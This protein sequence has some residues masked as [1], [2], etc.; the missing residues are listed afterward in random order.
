M[1]ISKTVKDRDEGIFRCEVTDHH[2][3]K[4]TDGQ[5]V[6]I[7]DKYFIKLYEDNEKSSIT[8]AARKKGARINIGYTAYPT[9]TTVIWTN[10]RGIEISNNG[11][12]LRKNKYKIEKSEK[13]II[14]T[15]TNP[16]LRDFGTYTLFASNDFTNK[17]IGIKLLVLGKTRQIL[18][19]SILSKFF[20]NI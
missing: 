5:H 14:L 11:N 17:S 8:I 12:V 10:N 9:L 7:I 16:D 19:S 1:T 15:I 13:N 20:I 3:A 4:F 18:V 6:N 2:N